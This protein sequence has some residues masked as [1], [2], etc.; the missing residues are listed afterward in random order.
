MGR[1][2]LRDS[3]V[4]LSLAALVGCEEG[5]AD[6]REVLDACGLPVPCPVVFMGWEYYNQQL[7]L[8]N[9]ACIHDVLARSEAAHLSGNYPNWHASGTTDWD[10]YT[11]DDGVAL[12]LETLRACESDD[13]CSGLVQQ[14]KLKPVHEFECLQCGSDCPAGLEPSDLVCGQPRDWCTELV[15]IEP[16]CP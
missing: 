15:E 5:Q 10:L 1:L 11:A 8:M 9:A 13:S 4:V 14:C 3:L 12:L 2:T 16:S 7:P 6:P